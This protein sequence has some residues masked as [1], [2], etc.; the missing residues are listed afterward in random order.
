MP[1]TNGGT[2]S[3]N[4]ATKCTS[5]AWRGR[6]LHMRSGQA[7]TV[8][9]TFSFDFRSLLRGPAQHVRSARDATRDADTI[10]RCKVRRGW[11]DY[12]VQPI[13]F[14]R[15]AM[16]DEC[17][18]NRQRITPERAARPFPIRPYR[19]IAFSQGNPGI[20]SHFLRNYR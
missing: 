10:I 2:T 11:P 12:P 19:K 16:R 6:C 20:F 4:I 15:C 7:R 3:R 5:S 1:S 18:R 8:R 14:T 17:A 13:I 9:H